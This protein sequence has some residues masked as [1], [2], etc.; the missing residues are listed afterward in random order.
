[1]N[2]LSSLPPEALRE[3]E[4]GDYGSSLKVQPRE[5]Y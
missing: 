4:V 3:D 1:M 5:R 2:L